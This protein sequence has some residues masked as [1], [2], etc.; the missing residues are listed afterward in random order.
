MAA[1][2]EAKVFINHAKGFQKVLQTQKKWE[3][4]KDEDFRNARFAYKRLNPGDPIMLQYPT[5]KIWCSATVLERNSNGTY[6]V[7]CA[8]G[9]QERK[10]AAQWIRPR[11][12]GDNV[13]EFSAVWAW[14]PTGKLTEDELVLKND[15][16]CSLRSGAVGTW[17][18]KDT[19]GKGRTTIK[20]QL[21]SL[22][23][24]MER[25][26][27]TMLLSTSTAHRAIMMD[28]Y[29]DCLDASYW[30]FKDNPN[31]I[32]RSVPPILGRKPDVKR[33]E[34]I[35]N[36][37]EPMKGKE[38]D[39]PWVGLPASMADNFAA[40][41]YGYID[42]HQPGKY[43]FS[44]E[45]AHLARLTVDDTRIID[46]SAESRVIDGN[47]KPDGVFEIS[48][49]RYLFSGARS[50]ALQYV[51]KSGSNKA[52]VLYYNGPDTDGEK[53]PVPAAVLQ[54]QGVKNCP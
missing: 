11:G 4:E 35:V 19:K 50:M 46:I 16:M 32:E 33:S 9:S 10:V 37:A 49:E 39:E 24:D 30:A 48:G 36:Y 31:W 44:V 20:I 2:E 34:Q 14:K 5:N 3:L 47:E 18:P 41:W 25:I 17:N 54:H 29:D 51:H 6:D 8:H 7:D 28:K 43:T 45:A 40:L 22:I 1:D 42:I 23:L 13:E 12:A 26:S 27:V 15:G 38:S 52:C 53:R 21:G